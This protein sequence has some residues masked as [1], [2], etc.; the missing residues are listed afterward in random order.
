MVSVFDKKSCNPILVNKYENTSI[1][2]NR[3]NVLI[4]ICQKKYLLLLSFVVIIVL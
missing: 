1:I 2:I 4:N 3:I